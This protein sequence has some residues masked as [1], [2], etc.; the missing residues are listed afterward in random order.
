M[1]ISKTNKWVWIGL[2]INFFFLALLYFCTGT[3]FHEPRIEALFGVLKNTLVL[4]FFLQILNILLIKYGPRYATGTS[5]ILSLFYFPF[6]VIY[7][8]GCLF[9]IQQSVFSTYTYTISPE[10][11]SY[12]NEEYKV[13]FL[14]VKIK[15]RILLWGVLSLVSLFIFSLVV[16]VFFTL[17]IMSVCAFYQSRNAFFFS[18]GCD[19]FLMKPTAFSDVLVIRKSSI[20]NVNTQ[21]GFAEVITSEGTLKFNN[22]YVNK[23]EFEKIIKELSL[24]ALNN[25]GNQ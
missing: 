7:Y 14:M 10:A 15:K 11:V 22:R 9:S 3:I 1:D 20:M 19:C 23:T 18:D 16:P 13:P 21:D 5:F 24:A 12:N 17:F 8:I 6:G 2:A 25:K 4:V